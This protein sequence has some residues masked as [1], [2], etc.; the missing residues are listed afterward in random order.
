[1][2][3]AP[4]MGWS[5]S[6]LLSNASAGGQVEQPSEVN[7]S[8]TT[9]VRSTCASAA[10]ATASRGGVALGVKSKS[11]PRANSG[12]AFFM[13]SPPL[14]AS[15]YLVGG[16]KETEFSAGAESIRPEPERSDGMQ[17][18]LVGPRN[19]ELL[20]SLDAQNIFTCGPRMDL[21]DERSVDKH[22]AMNADESVWSEFFRDRGHGLMKKIRTRH[23]VEQNVITLSLDRNHIG[24]IKKKNPHFCL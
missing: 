7:S 11:V 12:S 23:A 10:C 16:A 14:F 4:P 21:F 20:S 13:S 5:V 18:L 6:S 3:S 1:M 22:G 8:T 19:M 24:G 2:I 15:D 17:I 9:G